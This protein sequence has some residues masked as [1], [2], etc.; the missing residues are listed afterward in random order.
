M[1]FPE[2]LVL[3]RPIVTAGACED[4]LERAVR[5]HARLV[6]KIAYSVLRNH[7][8]AEDAVQEIFLKFLRWR[9]RWAGVRDQRAWLAKAAWR[10]ALGRLKGRPEV[11]LEEAAQQVSTLRGQGADVEE[12]ASTRQMK[13]LLE[14]MI[15][16]LPHDLRDVVTLSTVEELNSREIA[17]A[18]GIPE[19]S[20][21]T[22]Q[23][24]AREMLREKLRAVMERKNG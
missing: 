6:Y 5:E 14:R 22:R 10:M 9:G 24:R 19:G 18:L 20:V 4:E 15:A 13:M 12:I 7:D 23:L 2:H 11:G 1:T 8:D 3:S 16:A 21:R 17:A